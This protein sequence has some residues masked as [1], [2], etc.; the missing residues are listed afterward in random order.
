[1]NDPARDAAR[2]SELLRASA[3]LEPCDRAI[4]ALWGAAATSS[5]TAMITAVLSQ[6]RAMTPV[7]RRT[8]LAV[9][10]WSAAATAVAVTAFYQPPAGWLW[11]LP[12]AAAVS[13]GLTLRFWK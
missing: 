8:S 1:M 11:L 7:E 6:W 2:V 3:L 9:L 13:L 4:S 12:P 5:T 10:L